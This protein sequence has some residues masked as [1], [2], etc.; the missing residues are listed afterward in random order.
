MANEEFDREEQRR[1]RI[2]LRICRPSSFSRAKMK[3]IHRDKTNR[4]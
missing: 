2:D 3:A 1:K 4:W